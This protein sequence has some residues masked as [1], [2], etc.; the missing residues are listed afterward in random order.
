MKRFYWTAAIA[1]SLVLLFSSLAAPVAKAA[2]PSLIDEDTKKQLTPYLT[3]LCDWIMT[4][5]VGSGKLKNTDDTHRSIFING[6]LARV[7]YAA[8]QITGNTKYLD[9]ALRWCDTF[10]AQQQPVVTLQGEDAGYWG[11]MGEAGNIYFG[12]A[13]TAATALAVISKQADAAR[14]KKYRAALE[15]F[16]LFVRHGCKE[17]P[18]NQGRG[19]C[20][21]WVIA[22]GKDR[23]A[24]GCGYY[25]G[26]L[27]TAP[28]IISTAVNAGA[29]HA[30]LYSITKDPE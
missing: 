23:G 2:A 4:L 16:S 15:R 20:P 17:D 8:H 28:Y 24:L 22:S 19:G 27:S 5:D 9:E 14:Q 30:M 13:G 18:Q 6:N 26:H 21:G 12:D 10:V 3:D 29:F 7:L 25:Q 1:I 11:D